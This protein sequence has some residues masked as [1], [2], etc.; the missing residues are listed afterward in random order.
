MKI[1][2]IHPGAM[3]V[4]VASSL[5]GSHEIFWASE[6]R[7]ETTRQRAQATG[8]NELPTLA[9]V[10]N[11]CEAIIS[12]CPPAAATEVAE[13]VSRVR[14]SGF[15]YIDANSVAPETVNR[16]AGLF[17]GN[18][19]DATLTGEPG[20]P[21]TTIWLSG[22]RASEVCS[23]F[24]GTR[25]RYRVIGAELGEASAFKMCSG[26]RS[27]IIPAVWATLITAASSF[28]PEVERCVR[29]HLGELGYDLDLESEKISNRSRKAA[30][31]VGE[32]DESAKTMRGVN[33]PSGFSEAAAAT[34]Q[35]IA[36]P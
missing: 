10:V 4:A 21:N 35:R 14:S 30:R 19:V 26:L 31:W 12:L 15:L 24:E 20:A 2:V 25:I 22:K 23:L 32:M 13:D 36:T 33:L 5:A 7:S 18:T 9:E 3:G 1:G 6:G 34:Y 29:E 16:I 11:T 8:L 28:G 27:K 17:P